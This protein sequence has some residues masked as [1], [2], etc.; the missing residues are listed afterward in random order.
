LSDARDNASLR[1]GSLSLRDRLRHSLPIEG[2]TARLLI[3]TVAVLAVMSVLNPGRFL[4]YR[5]FASMCFQFPELGIFALAIM[6]SLVTGGIDLSIIS[7][8]N[9]GGILA[10]LILTRATGDLSA[11][12]RAMYIAGAVV[13]ALAA[14]VLCGWI[15]GLLI[16]RFAVTPIL[17]TLGTMQL[18]T[19]I[20]LVITKGHAIANYPQAAQFIGNGTFAG[21]PVP[22]LIF[23]FLACLVQVLLSRTRLGLHLYLMG[24]NPTAARFSGLD[25]RRLLGRT[26]LLTAALST[27]A[28]LVI[29]SRTNSAKADY[30]GSYLLQAVLVA[31]LGGVNPR[32][33]FGSAWGILLAVL[34]LQ[35][36]SS[37]L[38]MLQ[39]DETIGPYLN[40]F[41]KEFTWGALLLVV[42]VVNYHSNRS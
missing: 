19:G 37:G 3:I 20:A 39:L 12:E 14:G 35:F 2:A 33:G 4:T 31:I 27:V 28:G 42:M 30:G 36:L 26:Y 21:V 22:L 5:N 17:A 40:N 7:I 29:I 16:S 15:N 32:G 1:K 41:A 34:S 13:A 23:L 8:G 25:V 10:A 6:L 24:T 11:T 9:L 38:N 18:F